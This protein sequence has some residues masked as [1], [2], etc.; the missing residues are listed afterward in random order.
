MRAL[1]AEGAPLVRVGDRI[2]G[3]D[4]SVEIAA[5]AT[6]PIR[7]ARSGHVLE[8]VV[9]GARDAPVR[10]ERGVAHFP[11]ALDDGDLAFVIGRDRVEEL[12]TVSSIGGARALR[13]TI[14]RGRHLT[15]RS[16]GDAIEIVDR[17]GTAHF[18]TEPA[19][20]VDSLGRRVTVW[21]VVEPIDD[22]HD[23]VVGH[24]EDDEHLAYP[25]AIDPT[26][27]SIT[28][29]PSIR[30][31]HATVRLPSGKVMLIGGYKADALTTTEIFDPKTSAWSSGAPMITKRAFPA[32]TTLLSGKIFV[33]GGAEGL[34][35]ET[36]AAEIYDETT[37]SW[38]PAAESPTGHGGEGPSY[39]LTLPSGKVFVAALAGSE[40]YDP[41]TNKWAIGPAHATG[42]AGIGVPALISGGKVLVT[43]ALASSAMWYEA[44]SSV[45]VYDPATTARATAVASMSTKRSGHSTLVMASGKVLVAGG[46][47]QAIAWSGG[48]TALSTTEIYDPGTNTWTSGPTMG[49]KRFNFANAVLPSGRWIVAGSDATEPRTGLGDPT[50]EVFDP[51]TLKWL[52]LPPMRE[53]R[54]RSS[55][56]AL[57][58]GRA[59]IAGGEYAYTA[60]WFGALATSSAEIFEAKCAAASDCGTGYCVDGVCCDTACTGACLA[61]DEPGKAGTCS[62]ISGAPR[63]GHPACG[64][65]LCKAG[66]CGTTCVTSAD[67]LNGA[68]CVS[69]ACVLKANSEACTA[70]VQ[71]ASGHCYDGVCCNAQCDYKCVACDIPTRIGTCAAVDGLPH[72]DPRRPACGKD[73][74]C[75]ARCD[76]RVAWSCDRPAPAGGTACSR[77]ECTGGVE[78]HV[79]TCDGVETCSGLKKT[80][81]PYA[82]DLLVCKS[83]C[84][85]ST[86]CAPGF[87]CES[88][89]CVV[90]PDAGVDA[91]TDTAAVAEDT[92]VADVADTFVAET[93]ADTRADTE[94]PAA[95]P[96]PET[97]SLYGCTASRGEACGGWFVVALLLLLRRRR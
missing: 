75:A 79:G 96:K 87:R 77:D 14:T 13:W 3:V 54:G 72:V 90:I 25:I 19:F 38:A 45:E 95:T 30:V 53:A 9:V 57:T 88:M 32:A 15:S 48:T 85:V 17:G 86:D 66:V 94:R 12:R 60:P 41:A 67:C 80:C 49:S 97:Q 64:A 92:A 33:N 10:I 58:D 1:L 44:G 82:C 34:W 91:T 47:T 11:G 59:L 78:T 62:P 8:V 21:F 52:R 84:S 68:A 65:A 89:T 16:L 6:A 63:P 42:L 50:A 28:A 56:A 76:G 70:D 69:G 55:M 22:R 71:C 40:V 24:V 37:D 81:S 23:A 29:L 74:D 18:R 36:R 4:S 31:G 39:A 7:L 43:G 46:I 93:T 51:T 73:R 61:C 2:V 26:W 20:A 5:H 35:Y 83:T 27:R